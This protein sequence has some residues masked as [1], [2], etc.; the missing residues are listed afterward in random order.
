VISEAILRAYD[1]IVATHPELERKG[2][3]MPYTSING[4]M[5]SFLT[6]DGVL[7]LRLPGVDREA[8]V[9]TY[10]TKLVEQH[11][12][13]MKEYV[14]VPADLFDRLDELKPWFDQS[15]ECVVTLKPKKTTRTR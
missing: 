2:A 11:G 3:T 5:F 6:P 13:V 14:A 1:A 12:A 4:H 15:C 8:F 7:A 9:E 10:D